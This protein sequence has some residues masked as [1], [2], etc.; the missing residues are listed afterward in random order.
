MVS[1]I[2]GM[3][4]C[5]DKVCVK[6]N[7]YHQLA[8]FIVLFGGFLAWGALEWRKAIKLEKRLKKW[9]LARAWYRKP[10]NTWFNAL[11]D[12]EIAELAR[13][14]RYGRP[15]SHFDI[16]DSFT[17]AMNIQQKFNR[18]VREMNLPYDAINEAA[19]FKAIDQ[20]MQN[21]F[22]NTPDARLDGRDEEF[23]KEKQ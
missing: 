6:M 3:D 10:D 17:L 15:S 5:R 7:G 1:S 4:Y 20:A 9:D 8:L 11:F 13:R 21:V 12:L 16:V 14:S 19:R 2:F 23:A 22:F 18:P